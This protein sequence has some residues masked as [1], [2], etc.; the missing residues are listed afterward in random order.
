MATAAHRSALE[1]E[2]DEVIRWRADELRRA[3]YG[4]RAA[5]LLALHREVDLH[6]AARL[7]EQ[8]CPPRI[9]LRILL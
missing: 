4:E 5:L 8:G 9:A 6:L 7:L 1:T 3:G 2:A